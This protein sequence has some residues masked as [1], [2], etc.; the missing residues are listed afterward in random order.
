MCLALWSKFS[1]CLPSGNVHRIRLSSTPNYW[2]PGLSSW[3]EVS[4]KGGSSEKVRKSSC[5]TDSGHNEAE[6]RPSSVPRAAVCIQLSSCCGMG[7][8]CPVSTAA[9]KRVRFGSCRQLKCYLTPRLLIRVYHAFT[10]SFNL[11]PYLLAAALFKVDDRLPACSSSE[12]FLL[13]WYI[14][15]GLPDI[16]FLSKPWNQIITSLVLNFL[17]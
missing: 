4:R 14:G 12:C 5:W 9:H 16:D 2:A 8:R 11:L 15:V 3:R 10:L 7:E 6:C 1:H 13:F 17:H